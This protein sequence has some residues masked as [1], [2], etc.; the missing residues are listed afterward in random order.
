MKRLYKLVYSTS[1]LLWLLFS[2]GCAQDQKSGSK[3]TK[4]APPSNIDS[5]GNSKELQLISSQWIDTL[6]EK[7]IQ[8]SKN[9]L[10]KAAV[11]EEWLFDQIKNADTAVYFIY[12][13]GHDDSDEGGTNP[14]FVTDQWVY[15]DTATRKLYE[16]DII[17]DSLVRWSK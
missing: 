8:V 3:K 1:I 9:E 10:V 17:K 12:Q 4:F 16:Y 2:L 14:R 6:I 11:T 13:I 5:S 15:V 7:Y